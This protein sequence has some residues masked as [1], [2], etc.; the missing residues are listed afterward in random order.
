MNVF[1][2]SQDKTIAI[3]LTTLGPVAPSL[4]RVV[5]AM[6]TVTMMTSVQE[7]WCVAQ[8]IVLLGTGTWT[9]A[10]VGLKVVH[11]DIILVLQ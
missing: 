2:H 5:R 7:T 8:T 9:A 3:Q 4:L 10:R 1:Y 6:E 11:F